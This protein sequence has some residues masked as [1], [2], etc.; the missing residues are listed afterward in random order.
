MPSAAFAY[1]Q[2]AERFLQPLPGPSDRP[3]LPMAAS[4]SRVEEVHRVANM[5]LKSLETSCSW[6]MEPMWHPSWEPFWQ[7]VDEVQL[8]LH[9][10]TFPTPPPR[11]RQKVPPVAILIGTGPHLPPSTEIGV[12]PEGPAYSYAAEAFMQ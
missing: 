7:A 10:H 1:Q 11:A 4:S 2:L 3:C 6:D 5:G 8:P 9:F 12:T